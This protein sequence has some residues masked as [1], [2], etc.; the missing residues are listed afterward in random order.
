MNVDQEIAA[1]Q[2]QVEELTA[3]EAIRE[4]LHRYAR[5]TDR[6][7]VALLKSC[8]WTGAFDAH[9]GAFAGDAHEFAEFILGPNQLAQL[10]DL[11][12]L[13][14]NT[15]IDLDLDHDRAFVESAFVCT[16]ELSF[17]DSKTADAQSEGR[18][19]DLFERRKGEWKIWRR[20]MQSEKMVWR[21]RPPQPVPSQAPDVAAKRFP[22]DPV[23]LGFDFPEVLPAP[24]RPEGNPWSF[25]ATAIERLAQHREGGA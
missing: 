25:I 21:I 8:Y 2:R 6:F 17:G 23:Y 5:A 10:P 13:I 12:H 18:Y 3:R 4:V 14:S 22:S 9:G 15:M 24:S 7:D 19:F 1:L 16:I 11:R 20:L